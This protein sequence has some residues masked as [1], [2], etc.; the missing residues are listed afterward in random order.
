[1]EEREEDAPA[2]RGKWVQPE[3]GTMFPWR[4]AQAPSRP[5]WSQS[6][7]CPRSLASVLVATPGPPSASHDVYPSLAP[8]EIM[9]KRKHQGVTMITTITPP[10]VPRGCEAV[11][12]KAELLKGPQLR[13]G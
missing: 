13:K 2:S 9:F 4:M 6:Q 7:A 5:G 3:D 8:V 10:P 12:E 1:M 11:M